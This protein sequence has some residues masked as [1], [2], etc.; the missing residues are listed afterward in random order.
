MERNYKDKRGD[1]R[2]GL[3][4]V[5]IGNDVW[6]VGKNSIVDNN[7][8]QVI[9][10]PNRK[11]YHLWGKDVDFI[12]LKM[13]SYDSGLTKSHVNR[14][15]NTSIEQRV[16]IYILTSI[17]DERKNWCFNL[18]EKPEIGKRV[19]V[20]YSNGTVKWVENFNGE[21][22]QAELISKRSKSITSAYNY[23]VFVNPIGYRRW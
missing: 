21:F 11:E 9:Y 18:G 15:G 7:K 1:L 13:E 14:G 19:K 5:N 3:K 17:L 4:K 8:H 10:G 22:E 16:K 6:L 2:S 20:I 23:T 12:N